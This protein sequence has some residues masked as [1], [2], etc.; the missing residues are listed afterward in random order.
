MKNISNKTCVTKEECNV[1]IAEAHN[2]RKVRLINIR[3]D[4][5]DRNINYLKVLA[6]ERFELIKS[7]YRK[8]VGQRL[9]PHA[10][11]IIEL[12]VYGMT[13]KEQSEAF[14][15]KLEKKLHCEVLSWAVHL[16]E[17]HYDIETGEWIPNYHAHFIVD[18]TIWTH[19]LIEAPKRHHGKTVKDQ[20]GQV[21]MEAKD[22]YARRRRM[23]KDEL[24]WLQDLASE[25]TGLERGTPSTI[26][27]LRAIQYRAAQVQKDIEHLN[28]KQTEI[29]N[30]ISQLESQQ[31]KLK[32]DNVIAEER[33][34]KAYL[35]LRST[36]KMMV[37]T[38]DSDVASMHE[39][40][41]SEMTLKLRRQRD[42]LNELASIEPKQTHTP[43]VGLV[44]AFAIAIAGVIRILMELFEI[45]MR[46]LQ[47]QLS[48][49]KKQVQRQSLMHSAKGAL[50]A[51]LDKPAN[52][53]VRQL[54]AENQ[55]LREANAA[56]EAQNGELGT[57]NET[58][59][60]ELLVLRSEVSANKDLDSRYRDLLRE[61][62]ATVEAKNILAYDLIAR[63]QP[64]EI[65]RLEF[66]GI[67]AL[68][69]AKRWDVIKTKV[70]L[71]H[72]PQVPG[73][74][75]KGGPKK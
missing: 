73:A 52:E 42:G 27:R 62:N 33:L 45:A 68:L 59:Q 43:I 8:T 48:E 72:A 71:K 39:V 37:S 41:G 69:G 20:D 17:G 12:V 18:C 21:V 22:R 10:Q 49:L 30:N 55:A 36:A 61:R 29:Q 14:A 23:G 13:T 50:T 11:P 58:N 47:K 15:R 67:P 25:V 31:H 60:Q 64:Q 51:L 19:D 38:L 63:I 7:V 9:Q 56:L 3:E 24:S 1:Y 4:L 40:I 34:N 26:K 44:S 65:V 35:V 57:V 16:D 5:S 53:Q 66:L 28:S 70:N 54:A 75:K 74:P 46:K 6:A 2:F 32:E